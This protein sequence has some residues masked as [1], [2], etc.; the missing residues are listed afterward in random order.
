MKLFKSASKTGTIALKSF[1][2]T[3]LLGGLLTA[4]APGAQATL[5]GQTVGCVASSDLGPLTCSS[6]STV[7]QT[8]GPEFVLSQASIG[9]PVPLT[10]DIDIGESSVRIGYSF[11][12]NSEFN[13]VQL[14]VLLSNLFWLGS[15]DSVISG[16]LLSVSGVTGFDEADISFSDNVIGFDL[17]GGPE[18]TR[19]N[20]GSSVTITLITEDH[21][22]SVSVPEPATLALFGLGLAGFGLARRGIA[23]RR[24]T[25]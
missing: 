3:L 25:A 24:R 9:F 20:S 16:F 15:P 23:Q 17:G 12:G 1:L 21:G 2:G 14:D 19:W 11:Q 13:D 6:D 8:T 7:V 10:W 5:I 4:F 22:P 18:S